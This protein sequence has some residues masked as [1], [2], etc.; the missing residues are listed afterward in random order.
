M[1]MKVQVKKV[2][3]LDRSLYMTYDMKAI[4]AYKD[5]TGKSFLN[6]ITKFSKDELDELELINMIVSCLREQPY[7]EP[8]EL[9]YFKD[10]N[11]IALISMYSETMANLLIAGMPKNTA[12]N[13]KKIKK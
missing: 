8:L 11:P 6:S 1:S 2:N 12:N 9:D 13:K 7:G 10:I 5:R 4:Q 3:Y